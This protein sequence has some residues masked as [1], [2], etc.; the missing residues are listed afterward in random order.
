MPHPDLLVIGG[1][2][3]GA[4][5]A[6]ALAREGVSVEVL[7]DS[8][9]PGAATAASAGMLAPFAD[10]RPADPTFALAIRGRDLYR[11][12]A[13]ALRDET[14]IDIGLWTGGILHVAFT[15]AEADR[16]KTDVAWQRQSGLTSDWLDPEELRQLAPAI[17]HQALGAF[18]A[19]E[20]G[21]IDPG[22]L[23]RALRQSATA[24]GATFTGGARVRSLILDGA[25][26]VG[27]RTD[28]GDHSADGVLI[29]AGAWSGRIQNLPR[30]LAVEPIRGQMAALDWP[31]GDPICIAFGAGCYLLRRGEEALVG[32]TM[33]YVGFDAA[34]TPAAIGALAESAG[35]LYP[36]LAGKPV[37]R[38]WAGL[39][40]VTPDGK[41]YIG[42]DPDIEGLW[43]ATGHGR[44]G[45]V[46]AG[47]TA[48]IV[49]DLYA[50]QP[51]EHD[52]ASV[53]PA[54]FWKFPKH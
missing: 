26:V 40:P 46:L 28:R 50:G 52:L 12:L 24:A 44:N 42:P 10:A 25:R 21:C 17:S 22:A 5:C 3:I 43:Y 49:A 7:E 34:V 29:S 11:E 33:E 14:G 45:I 47:I 4:A 41:P 20:D 2:V 48:E 15:Q 31:A 35:R 53:S 19:P 37:R 36:A 16:Y 18:R 51:P 8:G 6:R 27:A 39:R 32:A 23:H 9:E 38:S 30:P 54:R 13:P 1:G